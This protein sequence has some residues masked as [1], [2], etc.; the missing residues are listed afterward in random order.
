MILTYNL[1]FKTHFGYYECYYLPHRIVV[2]KCGF[3]HLN[4]NSFFRNYFASMS[5]GCKYHDKDKIC[6]HCERLEIALNVN[7]S[8]VCMNEEDFPKRFK[9]YDFSL[10]AKTLPGNPFFVYDKDK[11]LL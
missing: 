6:M 5:C 10:Y 2:T 3:H 4:V 11:I 7:L 8:K 9:F 1:K